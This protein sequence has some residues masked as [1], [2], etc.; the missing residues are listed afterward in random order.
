MP[1]LIGSNANR[2]AHLAKD[3]VHVWQANL[4]A[5]SVNATDALNL[6]DSEERA[7][8]A[9]FFSDVERA[10]FVASRSMLRSLLS[11]YLGCEPSG[12]RFGH[13]PGGK[14]HLL[15]HD[16]RPDLRFNASRT[17]NLAMVAI[18]MGRDVGVD[19]E[20]ITFDGGVADVMGKALTDEER[21]S[22][23]ALPS[24]AEK[25]AEFFKLWVRKEAFLKARGDGLAIA[26]ALVH[27]QTP[28]GKVY[29]RGRLQRGWRVYD[30]AVGAGNAA[31]IAAGGKHWRVVLNTFNGHKIS[32]FRD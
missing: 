3:T 24:Q 2:A 26:P 19:I 29:L 5:S 8:A 17:C 31:A 20:Q 16:A 1:P 15:R 9:K 13:A 25:H 7:R 4:H 21:A 14:P 11:F 22:L 6:L 12:V 30:V 10:E 32:A 18:A 23:E 28:S 27:A